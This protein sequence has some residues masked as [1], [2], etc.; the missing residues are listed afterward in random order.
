MAVGLRRSIFGLVEFGL[1]VLRGMRSVDAWWEGAI[2][3]LNRLAG[4]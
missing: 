3:G 1:W 4:F 2:Q